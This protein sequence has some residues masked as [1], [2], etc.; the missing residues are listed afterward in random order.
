VLPMAINRA[1][2]R[3]LRHAP[4]R[5][6]LVAWKPPL[7]G[8]AEAHT[9]P[10]IWVKRVVEARRQTARL[11]GP[12]SQLSRNGGLDETIRGPFRR[13]RRRSPGR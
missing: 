9:P 8:Y 4:A 3:H 7:S 6:E 5:R 13:L 10:F 12:Q 11:P 2:A 1:T